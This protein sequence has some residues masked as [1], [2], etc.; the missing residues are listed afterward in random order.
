MKVK[1]VKALSDILWYS[2]KIGEVFEVEQN[3]HADHYFDDFGYYTKN[4]S[5]GRAYLKTEDVEV[6]EYS[7]STPISTLEWLYSRQDELQ[8]Y[9]IDC[10]ERGVEIDKST[11]KEYYRNQQRI[12]EI[13][14][15]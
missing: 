15:C 2:N 9:V 1:I 7:K 12:L 5:G 10:L 8:A 14:K 11:S 4:H 3:D 6:V 13:E